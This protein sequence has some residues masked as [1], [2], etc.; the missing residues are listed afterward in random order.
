MTVWTSHDLA[1]IAEADEL[2]LASTGRE[3]LRPYTTMWVVRV[4]DDLYVR[5]AYGPNNPW[6]VGP[7][8]VASVGSKP[9]VWNGM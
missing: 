5:S 8:Q 2:Q 3:T 7:R 6:Y 4:G 9:A 1:S